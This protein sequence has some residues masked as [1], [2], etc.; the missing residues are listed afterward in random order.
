[1]TRTSPGRCF[2]C[3]GH[4]KLFTEGIQGAKPVGS[5]DT[6]HQLCSPAPA[7]PTCSSRTWKR[8]TKHLKDN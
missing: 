5:G 6:Q 3:L 7:T 1:M 8:S 2:L 4:S